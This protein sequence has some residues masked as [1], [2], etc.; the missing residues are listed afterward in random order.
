M[1]TPAIELISKYYPH[2]RFTFLGSYVSIEALKHHPRCE[3]AI[4]DK[5]KKSSSRLVATYKLA[6]ELGEFNF[7]VNFRNQIHASLLAYF[8]G[9]VLTLARSSWHAKTLLSHAKSISTQQHL[10][11]QYIELA[12]QN[13][14]AYQNEIVPLKL[15]IE[16]KSFSKPS[17]GINAGATY[18][19]AKRWYPER[20]AAVGAAFA[21][22]YNIIIFGG[23]NEVEM[24]QEI[25][26]NLIKLNISNFTNMAGKTSVEELCA[27]VGGCSLF[28]TND[29]G[30]MHIAAA[31]QVPTVAIFGPTKHTETSQWMNK[32]STIVRHDM[33]C[34]PCM[35]RE[36]PL[37]H[38]E[39]MTSI[40]A[41]EVIEA[42]KKI[43]KD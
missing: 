7:I 6:K 38:H 2:A 14:D 18:G 11:L 32:K 5:T 41:L 31:Y 39:C 23:P 21:K 17:L 15:Y 19:S 42:V 12:M 27:S 25:E 8:T 28:I 33:E 22:E 24:A 13:T 26:D 1:T 35:K 4:V 29:S 9:T 10:V 20:F 43:L 37:K 36:C 34:S 40:T 3:K 30:P 16:K